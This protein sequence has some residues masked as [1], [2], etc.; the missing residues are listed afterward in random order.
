MPPV[1]KPVPSYVAHKK[2]GRARV[3]WY[4]CV[5]VRRQKLLPG[6][7]NSPES[8]TAFA[9]F[10]LELEACPVPAEVTRDGLTVAELLLAYLDFAERHY[11]TPDGKST[12][13]I[14][15]VRVVIRAV[16]ELYADTPVSEFGPL[17]LKTARQRWVT[18][19]RSRTECNRRVGV[20]K[21]IIKWA[22]AEE[23]APPAV[24]QA[25]AAVTGLQKGRTHAH[26]CEPVGPVDSAI[27]DATLPHLSRYVRGMVQFQRLTGCRPGEVCLLRR[28]DIHMSNPVW[29]YTPSHHKNAWRGQSRVIAIGPK[30]QEVLREFFTVSPNDYLFSPRRAVEEHLE[31]RTANRKT[32][33][34]SS[35]SK[36][37]ERK[38]KTHP[39]RAPAEKYNHASYAV[40]VD[41]AC[42]RAFPLPGGLA[43]LEKESRVKWWRRLSEDERAA[44][45]AWRKKHRWHPNQLRHSFATEVRKEHGLEAAQVLLGHTNAD[46]T[47]IYA[48]RNV[49]LAATVAARIG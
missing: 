13:E 41:R 48:E 3:V 7:F 18:D 45:Q 47:Q 23:L 14:Y 39:K 34:W 17:A 25:L 10:Q 30:A 40:A 20:V 46:V 21:R 26:E 6:T 38:R 49:E 9:R 22:V 19:G 32:P 12:S 2:S 43:P 28:C 35:H 31:G 11:R 44:V 27:V 1:R 16:R 42:D 29:L 4:D 33:R 24:Y 5:G 37:N 36:R 8:R 15:E